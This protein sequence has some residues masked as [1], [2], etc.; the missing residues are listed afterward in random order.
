MCDH[1]P[2]NMTQEEAIAYLR[3]KLTGETPKTECGWTTLVVTFTDGEVIRYP[4]T[5]FLLTLDGVDPIVPLMNGWLTFESDGNPVTV[6]GVREF[7]LDHLS[8][9]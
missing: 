1:N 9:F 2:D 5:R 3:A 6:A 7:R 4:N 8:E